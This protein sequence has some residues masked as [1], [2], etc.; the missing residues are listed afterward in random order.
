M[1]SEK[2]KYNSDSKIAKIVII[3]AVCFAIVIQLLVVI[4]IFN[5]GRLE[6][7]A[8]ITMSSGLLLLWG[9]VVG[10]ISLLLKDKLRLLFKS[11]NN[12]VFK[13]FLIALIM[14]LLEEIIAVSMTNTAHLWGFHLIMFISPQALTL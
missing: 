10:S 9:G 4:H 12:Y 14:C 11:D 13:F 6:D 7:K 2:L 1:D 8:I 3:I 5:E